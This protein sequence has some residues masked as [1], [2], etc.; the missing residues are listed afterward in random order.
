MMSQGLLLNN[1]EYGRVH[2][3]PYSGVWA[4][5]AHGRP[6]HTWKPCGLTG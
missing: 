5:G 2:C 6:A 4:K 1:L 3:T